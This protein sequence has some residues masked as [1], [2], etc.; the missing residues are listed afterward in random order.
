MPSEGPL[1]RCASENLRVTQPASQDNARSQSC[2]CSLRF[3]LQSQCGIV[4]LPLL[5]QIR[6]ERNKP[7]ILSQVVQVSVTLEKWIAR[8]AFIG[9]YLQPFECWVWA[10]H[11]RVCRCDAI[12]TCDESERNLDRFRWRAG[13]RL[14][15]RVPCQPWLTSWL[16]RRQP[17]RPHPP[18]S[19]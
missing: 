16:P 2:A 3:R 18:A 11:E 15:L 12:R 6:H 1:F 7:W 8:E 14:R 13:S 19:P 17:P 9:G 5:L 4:M 10:I